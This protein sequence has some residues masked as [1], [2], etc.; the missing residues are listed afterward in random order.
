MPNES[1]APATTPAVGSAAAA[2]VVAPVV[3]PAVAEPAVVAPAVA[4]A[5]VVDTAAAAAVLEADKA[6]A[7]TVEKGIRESV[8]KEYATTFQA[9]AKKQ[10][11]AWVNAAKTDPEYGGA[12]FDANL[13]TAKSVLK[14]FGDAKF[15]AFLD[16]T[17]LGNHPEMIRVLLKVAKAVG[18]DKL[19]GTGQGL[20]QGQAEKSAAEL[21]YP[22]TPK[23]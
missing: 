23:K 18:P 17:G 22:S 2:A 14:S 1:A 11:D 3:A 20:G 6:K 12:E 4:A 15:T 5:S 19:I 16:S 9:A 7:A 10:A 13:N 21:L 8:E